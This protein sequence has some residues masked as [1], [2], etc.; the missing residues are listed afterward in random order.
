MGVS[1]HCSLR[2]K[3]ELSHQVSEFSA[4]KHLQGRF[5]HR[6]GHRKVTTGLLLWGCRTQV[7]PV[8]SVPR[9]SRAKEAGDGLERLVVWEVA[10]GGGT[11]APSLFYLP[12]PPPSMT[13][14]HGIREEGTGQGSALRNSQ[15]TVAAQ[16]SQGL[17]LW[18]A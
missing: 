11:A 1:S 18:M 14:K 5:G 9:R 2:G 7:L 16:P 12:I 4:S 13:A 15:N 17:A 3:P 10:W 6:E 8:S